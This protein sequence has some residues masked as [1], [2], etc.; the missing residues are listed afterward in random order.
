M[1]SLKSRPGTED[2]QPS[3]VI[4]MT[5]GEEEESSPLANGKVRNHGLTVAQKLSSNTTL[6]PCLHLTATLVP[7]LPTPLT[8]EPHFLFAFSDLSTK[9]Y[10]SGIEDAHVDISAS[11][12]SHHSHH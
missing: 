6:L 7:L 2:I 9:I 12:C 8:S 1:M 5:A 10:T 3:R 11:A 4:W